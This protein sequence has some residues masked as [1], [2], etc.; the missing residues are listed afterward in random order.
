MGKVIIGPW[1]SSRQPSRAI[2]LT[3]IVKASWPDLFRRL[4]AVFGP[5]EIL[6]LS[7]SPLVLIT[8]DMF[9]R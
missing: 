3:P 2:I 6:S 8:P 4:E 7:I 5:V 9:K 1:P